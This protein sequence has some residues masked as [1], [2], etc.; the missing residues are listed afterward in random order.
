MVMRPILLDACCGAGGATR[1]YQQAGWYVVG[2][3]INPQPNYCGDEFIQADALEYLE[4]EV[5]LINR[6]EPYW[7]FAAVHASPPCQAHTT[8]AK[9]NNANVGYYPDLIAP[10]RELL[11]ATG[12]PYVI[13]N[14]PSAPL[15]SPITLCGEM[16]GLD[17]IRH[18][19]FESNI[20]LMQPPHP[21]HRGRVAGYRHGEK[22]DGPYFAVYGNGGGKGTLQQWRGAMG[23]DW[24]QTKHEL[25]ESIPPAYTA[26]IGSQLIQALECAA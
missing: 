24:M 14:V 4:N 21:A 18:R 1:G 5:W 12:L 15:R 9:G 25:A 3:D 6:G 11:I 16:F 17:V 13:E 20:L 7:N 23:I 8:L 22:F 19:L 10:T 26:H 2:V